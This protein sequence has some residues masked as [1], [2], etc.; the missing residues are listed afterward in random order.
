MVDSCRTCDSC[1]EGLEQYCTGPVSFTG[2]YN[3]PF[4]PDG[5]NTFG[6]YSDHL[7][8][9]EHFVLTI[10]E[11]LKPHEAAPI[12]CAGVT[13]YSPLRHWKVGPGTVV[14][15]AGIGGLG[16]M[17]VKMARAMGARVVALTTSDDKTTDIRSLGAD[18]VV[19]TTSKEAMTANAESIDFLL[20]TIPY[21]HELIDYLKLLK[22]DGAMAVVGLLMPVKQTLEMMEILTKRRTLAGSLIGG[23][24]ETQE[25]LDFCAEHGIAP[26][27]EVIPIQD[28]NK[29]FKHLKAGDVRFRYVLDMSTLKADPDA[30]ADVT[31][32]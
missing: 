23:I 24:P 6:G 9:D 8:V 32:S 11:G 30:K 10:P 12:L 15:V 7:V 29:A 19:L 3:G 2:T 5:T 31:E 20:D 28:I 18:E 1:G 14:G 17:A 25:V 13:T 27:T 16:H 21:E 4:T 26:E 22:R